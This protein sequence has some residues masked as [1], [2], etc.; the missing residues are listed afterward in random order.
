MNQ[1]AELEG[2]KENPSRVKDDD[3][4][5][6]EEKLRK[7]FSILTLDQFIDTISK[8]KMFVP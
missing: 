8:R 4:E 5:E 6:E 7:E 1:K 3:E 2:N